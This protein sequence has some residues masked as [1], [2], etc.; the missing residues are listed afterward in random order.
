MIQLTN[1]E[2]LEKVTVAF[3]NIGVVYAWIC[4]IINL[5]YLVLNNHTIIT[6]Y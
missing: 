6:F 3:K 5:G 4:V 1:L 2:I